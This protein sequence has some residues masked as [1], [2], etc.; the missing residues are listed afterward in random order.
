MH[1]ITHLLISWTL[2]NAA[3]LGRRD[4]MLVTV[5]GVIPDLDGMGVIGDI[6]TEHSAHP[7]SL[8]EDYHHF[9]MHNLGFAIVVTLLA[10]PLARRRLL[11][12]LLVAFSFHLHLLCDLVGSRGPDGCQWAIPYLLPFSHAWNLTWRHQWALKAWPNV[13]L[14]LALLVLALWWSWKQGRSLLELF[15]L[16]ADA[17]LA[18]T[19]R[20]RFGMPPGGYLA[21]LNEKPGPPMD[22]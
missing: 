12:P 2:A 22:E 10:I 18:R 20:A 15:S 19:L 21:V 6:L 17:A 14:T 3:G 13:T 4:R 8:F 5:A 1:P 7:L 11:T 16:R 9:L